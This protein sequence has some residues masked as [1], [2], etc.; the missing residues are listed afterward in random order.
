MAHRAYRAWEYRR[1]VL[2]C[3]QCRE[4][5]RRSGCLVTMVGLLLEVGSGGGCGYR[6]LFRC[7]QRA[8]N[9]GGIERDGEC[10][11]LRLARI[12]RRRRLRLVGQRRGRLWLTS[13]CVARGGLRRERRQL[14]GGL[15]E[16]LE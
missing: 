1:I 2:R 11:R 8:E 10:D 6:P 14:P 3:R 4:L 9:F 12:V 16:V 15:R 5:I 7:L 13:R